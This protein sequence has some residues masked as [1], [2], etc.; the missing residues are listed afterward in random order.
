MSGAMKEGSLLTSLCKTLNPTFN[1]K[2]TYRWV[3]TESAFV[4]ESQSLI[5]YNFSIVTINNVATLFS[6]VLMKIIEIH[7]VGGS[8]EDNILFKNPIE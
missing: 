1:D 2:K 4:V 6:K 5:L 8:S 7:D 3:L